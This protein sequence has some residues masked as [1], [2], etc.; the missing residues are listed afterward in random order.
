MKRIILIWLCASLLA[1]LPA[2][3]ASDKKEEKVDGYLEWRRGDVIVADGQRIRTNASTKFKGAGDAT[4]RSRVPLG[5]E[6]KAKG[7]RLSDGVILASEMEAK[8]NG[9]AMFEKDVLALTNDMEKRWVT[10]GHVFEELSPGKSQDLGKLYRDGASVDRIRA[11]TA[12]LVPPYLKSA[13]FRVYVL[14]SKEWNAFACANGM[15]VV[16]SAMLN[17]MNDDEMAIVLGHELVHAT[18]EHTRREFKRGMFMGLMLLG[19]TAGVE[20]AVDDSKKKTKAT[21]ETLSML[22]LMAWKNSYGR[23]MEDQADR[24]GLRYAYEAGYDVRIAPRLW[25]RFAEKY[26]DENKVVNFFFGDHSLSKARA[27]NLEREIALN[28]SSRR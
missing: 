23:D 18:H 1:I 26:G 25:R 16:H 21:V 15:I 24:V 6:L 22:G 10:A 14:D 27:T 5:Y 8:P 28:Y 12:R 20:T 2:V 4:N 3:P 19:V 11:V 13:D 9:S 7:V 17:D